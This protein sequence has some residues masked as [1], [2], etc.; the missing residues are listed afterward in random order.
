MFGLML[1][2]C[3]LEILNNFKQWTLQFHFAL[4]LANYIASPG[5]S[6]AGH[7]RQ[8]IIGIDLIDEGRFELLSVTMS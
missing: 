3:C 2:C 5:D 4:G 1:C 7:Q 8:A 6:T